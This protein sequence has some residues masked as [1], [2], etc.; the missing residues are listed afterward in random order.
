MATTNQELVGKGLDLLKLGVVPFVERE[1]EAQ[2]SQA[3]TGDRRLAGAAATPVAAAIGGGVSSE[4]EEAKPASAASRTVGRFDDTSRPKSWQR[5]RM[6][7][8]PRSEATTQNHVK[9]AKP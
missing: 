3:R 7:K 4:E 1:L 6:P 9:E 8:Q 5:R 2:N